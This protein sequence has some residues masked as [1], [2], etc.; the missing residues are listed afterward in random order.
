VATFTTA[1]LFG[2]LERIMIGT[3]F[4]WLTWLAARLCRRADASITGRAD[5]PGPRRPR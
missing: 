3:G 2:L 4:A 1:G 5:D